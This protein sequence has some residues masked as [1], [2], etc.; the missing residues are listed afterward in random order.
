LKKLVFSI[1]IGLIPLIYS[2]TYSPGGENFVD[3]DQNTTP[4]QVQNLTLDLN[5]DTL[6]VWTKSR[7]N[8]NLVS[9]NQPIVGVIITL[10]GEQH[11]YDKTSG[12]ID[13]DP[14]AFHEGMY[15]M[16]MKVYTT[17]GTGS[18]ADVTGNEGFLFTK[19]WVVVFENPKAPNLKLTSS[20]ENGFIKF[21]WDKF[22]SSFF[23]AY[24]LSIDN[25]GINDRY[26]VAF[27]NSDSTLFI[28]S[29]Y[30]GGQINVTLTTE[31]YDLNR[32]IHTAVVNYTYDY[33]VDIQFAENLDSLTISWTPNPFQCQTY[34]SL[35]DAISKVLVP[36]GNSYTIPATGLGEPLLHRIDFEPLKST[37][38]GK[39]THYLYERHTLGTEDGLQFTDMLYKPDMN[40][41]FLKD[42]MFVREVDE[43]FQTAGNYDFPYDY[44]NNPTLTFSKDNQSLYAIV[45]Q[46]RMRFSTSDMK[47]LEELPNGLGDNAT[48][49]VMKNLNDTIFLVGYD[50]RFCLLNIQNDSIISDSGPL[51]SIRG[52]SYY[53]FAISSD[54]HYA[55]FCNDL[56]LHI[57]EVVDN[58]QIIVQ[59]EDSGNDIS[60][61]FNLRKPNELLVNAMDG[62]YVMDCSTGQTIR[63]LNQFV[64]NP[65]NFDPVTNNLLLVSYSQKKIFVYDYDNDVVKLELNH[66]ANPWDF[67]L[68]NNYIFFNS[69][70]HL[71]ITDYV[72]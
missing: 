12:Y 34:Y 71:A 55:A 25:K 8:F 23:H 1:L 21:S 45:N 9:D 67:R 44:N 72:H 53:R 31:F 65:I 37:I 26:A 70:Y 3:V 40:S 39:T 42:P 11:V 56:G 17:S 33:P 29:L 18:L 61:L 4:P 46:K 69:G 16:E 6:H 13:I 63:N 49:Q 7:Y 22:N 38:W 48:I 47:V 58:Q 62:I 2:C 36:S 15:P 41:Y 28:D 66:H 64:A 14:A 57:C 20:I 32:D 50:G 30:V 5:D 54:G 59:Y 24:K 27:Y 60:C 19:E 43:N 68:L 10:N 51:G 35:G 52:N